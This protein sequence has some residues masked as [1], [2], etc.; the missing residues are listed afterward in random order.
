MILINLLFFRGEA[1][2]KQTFFCIF[3]IYVFF[4]QILKCLQVFQQI[5]P[6][7][8]KTFLDGKMLWKSFKSIFEI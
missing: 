1:M 4:N 8:Q 3:Q 6:V 5:S 7:S 2:H